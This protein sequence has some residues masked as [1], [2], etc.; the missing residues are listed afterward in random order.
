M[1]RNLSQYTPAPFNTSK[2]AKW[3]HSYA[4]ATLICGII[5]GF[6]SFSYLHSLILFNLNFDRDG[7]VWYL[8]NVLASLRPDYMLEIVRNGIL[9][10]C[11]F[12]VA[13]EF[14][15]LALG[16]PIAKPLL[17]T[18][19]KLMLVSVVFHVIH[20]IVM[21][22][23]MVEMIDL[24]EHIDFTSASTDQLEMLQNRLEKIQLGLELLRLIP[25]LLEFIAYYKFYEWAKVL[26]PLY[27]YHGTSKDP[28]ETTK[29]IL[30]GSALTLGGNLLLLVPKTNWGV[31]PALLGLIVFLIGY[32][33]T[34]TVLANQCYKRPPPIT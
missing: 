12:L 18:I 25:L 20:L 1:E 8:T 27:S 29:L 11:L 13:F 28:H 24:L 16:S 4:L 15:K 5:V 6:V 32:F 9:L 7:L 26:S 10:V 23:S 31:W 3:L 21:Y 30:I 19:Y 22:N 2:M 17:N 14:K 34:A 33:Q